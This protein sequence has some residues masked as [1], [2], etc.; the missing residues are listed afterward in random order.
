MKKRNFYLMTALV[1]LSFTVYSGGG[2]PKSNEP[3]V[4]IVGSGKIE[5]K[6]ESLLWKNGVAYR[7]TDGF[8]TD[9]FV[10]G[11]D[12]YLAGAGYDGAQV[13]KNG[14]MQKLA[15]GGTPSS[16]FV[17]GN[18]VYV[19]GW[20]Y[21][22]T[23][24]KHVAV[25][26]KNGVM[27]KLSNEQYH[28]G[29]F[30]VFVSGKDVYVTGYERDAATLWKNGVAQY[31][32]GKPGYGEPRATISQG[33]SVFVSG[34]DVYVAGYEE[35]VNRSTAKLWKNGVVQNL[36]GVNSMANAVFVSG[37][38]VYV[39]GWEGEDARLWKNGIIQN[40]RRENRCHN[41]NSVFVS[42]NDVYVIGSEC[43]NVGGILWKNGIVQNFSNVANSVAKAIF[44][45]NE[46]K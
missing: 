32:I 36:S 9:V 43:E 6:E 22:E 33:H 44:V 21:N 1:A 28:A 4:Y 19:T 15:G 26:W 11:N 24:Q 34:N 38:D 5:N 42:G 2:E 29:A 39:T 25:L 10:S 17:S 18:D 27:Q 41:A 40:L 46:T 45:K 30:S 12:V 31:L 23:Y 7:I 3:D 35:T 14:V 20:V 13:W 37:N 8:A 16:I